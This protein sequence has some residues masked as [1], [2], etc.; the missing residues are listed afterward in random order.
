MPDPVL[1]L[2]P[3]VFAGFEVPE[4]L[5][6]G[7]RQRLSIHRLPGGGR[8]VDAMGYDNND[9]T[10]SGVFSGAD[11]AE[12]VRVLDLLRVEG[13]ALPLFWDG[14][15]YTVVIARF[16]T[17]YRNPHWLPYKISCAVVRDESLATVQAVAGLAASV[18]A[19]LGLAGSLG[20]DVSALQSAF[21]APGA[22][23][24][25]TAAFVAAQAAVAGS[26][27]RLGGAM[28][29]AGGALGSA[30]FSVVLS[31]AAT[32]ANGAAALGYI[33]RVGQNLS[34]ASD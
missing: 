34:H 7:G 8:V 2:G 10:W 12:R 30:D 28:S 29:I 9:V 22:T 16:D 15:F 25:G 26:L 31:S 14:F 32:L 33:G 3:V 19:D 1:T 6:F 20:I 11:A 4:T 13:A 18:A 5:R 27:A 24:L 17:E 23:T 21:A